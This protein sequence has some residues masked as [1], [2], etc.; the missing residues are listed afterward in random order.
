MASYC[1]DGVMNTISIHLVTAV[2]DSYAPLR[3]TV[4]AAMEK[5]P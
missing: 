4:V 1:G 5:S 3:A 2:K